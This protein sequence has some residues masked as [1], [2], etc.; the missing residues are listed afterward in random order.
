MTAPLHLS[1]VVLP[2]AEHRDLWVRDGR[3]TFEPVPGAE[4]VSRGGWLVPGL[5]DAHCH[6]G[7][8]MGGTHVE[9]LAGLR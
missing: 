9:D 2:Q 8:G 7:V 6:V 3:I 4:T 1:G 5:V